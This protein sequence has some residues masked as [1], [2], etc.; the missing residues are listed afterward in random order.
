M[1]SRFSEYGVTHRSFPEGSAGVLGLN[2]WD[3]CTQGKHST[4]GYPPTPDK[5]LFFVY[6]HAVGVGCLLTFWMLPFDAK[7][8]YFVDIPI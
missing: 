6:S 2:P 8:S 7:V 1:S 5:G 3:P 4:A